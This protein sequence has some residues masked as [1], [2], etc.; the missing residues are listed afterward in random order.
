M[1][2]VLNH[3]FSSFLTLVNVFLSRSPATRLNRSNVGGTGSSASGSSAGSYS[4]YRKEKALKIYTGEED[5]DEDHRSK[6]GGN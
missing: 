1:R 5:D 2:S 6:D 4:Y 3:F